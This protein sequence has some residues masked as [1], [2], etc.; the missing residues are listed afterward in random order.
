VARVVS[1]VSTD[2]GTEF[3]LLLSWNSLGQTAD[4]NKVESF[5]EYTVEAAVVKVSPRGKFV[6]IDRGVSQGVE[7]GMIIDIFKTDYDGTN[8]LVASGHI[9]DVGS[10]WAIV[11]IV[12]RYRDVD[13]ENGYVARGR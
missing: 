11:R 9:Q 2:E 13:L 7:K 5:K 3:K 4:Q 12:K 6:K 1:G 10:D 8:I